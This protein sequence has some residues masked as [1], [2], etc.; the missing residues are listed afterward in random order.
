[1]V[2]EDT[3]QR[4]QNLAFYNFTT[5]LGGNSNWLKPG[6]LALIKEPN[7]KY[8]FATKMPLIRVESPSGLYET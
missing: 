6:I 2:V 7:L 4:V 8:S 3:Q 5:D 1:V